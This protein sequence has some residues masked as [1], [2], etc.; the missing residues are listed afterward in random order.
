MMC[1]TASKK[2]ITIFDL[3]FIAAQAAAKNKVK[4]MIGRMS[5]FDIASMMFFGKI[6]TIKSA[7]L[8]FGG[9]TTFVAVV[10]MCSEARGFARLRMSKP[11]VKEM[12]VAN[13]KY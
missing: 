3:S 11:S 1:A 12:S 2:S 7:G 10:I 6:C 9:S 5:F 4:T 8:N 13:V